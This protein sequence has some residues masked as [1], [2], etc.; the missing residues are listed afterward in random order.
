MPIQVYTLDWPGL[1]KSMNRS[2]GG[3]QGRASVMKQAREKAELQDQL[4][5]VMMVARVPR[6]PFM[7]IDASAVLRFPVHRERDEGNFRSALEKALGDALQDTGRLDGDTPDKFRFGSLE[8]DDE[9]GPPRT[10][11]LLRCALR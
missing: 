9:L 4:G 7:R 10:L 1:P 2:R 5:I 11:I 8:F 6:K 3:N